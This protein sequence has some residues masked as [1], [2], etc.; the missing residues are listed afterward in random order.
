MSTISRRGTALAAVVLF[1]LLALVAAPPGARAAAPPDAGF[2]AGWL[3]GLVNEA[4]FIPGPADAPDVGATLEGAIALGTAGVEEATFDRMVGWLEANV[5]SVVAPYGTDSPGN[6]G[7][8]L[9][10]AR[11]AGLNPNVFGGVDLVARLG[12][13]LG[14]FAPGLYGADDPTYDGVFRQSL[15]ILGLDAAGA[16][17]PAAAIGWLID[18]QCDTPTTAAGGWQAYRVDL[19][20]P[21]DAP[22]PVLFVGPDTNATAM[23]V[24]AT[25]AAG[26]AADVNAALTFLAG[27]EGSGGAW[28]YIPGG[29]VDPNSTALVAIALQTA[30][31]DA[32][33]ARAAL[34]TWQIGCAAPAED[35]GAYASPFSDGFPDLFATRQ[36]IWGASAVAF[37]PPVAS[38]GPT[39]DPC[40][41]TTTTTSGPAGPTTTSTSQ[42]S[43][44]A[45]AVVVTPAFTG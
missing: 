4:G 22:D 39:P 37:P 45:G 5:D 42:N 38:F 18:Q 8:L 20:V 2:G 9:M 36:A 19:G 10:L 3:A 26:G 21:C 27:A 23:A 30:G 15:A 24:A 7:Y 13:T 16:S 35:R 40:A 32:S 33:G 43:L 34:A 41:P 29:D 12:A 44:P 25:V 1:V 28:P 14:A 17:V 6:L 11:Q 31:A